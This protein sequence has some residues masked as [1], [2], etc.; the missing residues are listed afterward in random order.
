MII[1]LYYK[2]NEYDLSQYVDLTDNNIN[3]TIEEELDSGKIVLSRVAKNVFSELDMSKRMPSL[4]R[5]Y[6]NN[7][8]GI[9]RYFLTGD[10]QCFEIIK[11]KRW[12]HEIG[13]IELTKELQLTPIRDM[14]I[15]QPQ[16]GNYYSASSARTLLSIN[17]A[18]ETIF[19][20]GAYNTLIN[21]GNVATRINTT[22]INDNGLKITNSGK[23]ANFTVIDQTNGSII[24]GTTIKETGNYNISLNVSAYN[25]TFS[26]NKE[27]KS[28]IFAG[29]IARL[30][31]INPDRKSVV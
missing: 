6:F 20:G 2:G 18:N 19:N 27:E 9:E 4:C 29:A 17:N 3:E 31:K 21:F 14:T 13:L 10:A 25:P 23:T 26:I 12:K 8:K 11:G 7:E 28:G 30:Y 24:D 15:T 16:D 5:L 1:K 22:S